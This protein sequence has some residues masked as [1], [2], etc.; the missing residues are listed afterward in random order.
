VNVYW[1][2]WQCWRL[3]GERRQRSSL[4]IFAA[5]APIFTV[6]P[7]QASPNQQLTGSG[8]LIDLSEA[9]HRA[10]SFGSSFSEPAACRIVRH[11]ADA[12]A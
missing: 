10:A 7:K 11:D 4:A 3:G 2:H 1:R 6:P 12:L 5:E 9:R 8:R